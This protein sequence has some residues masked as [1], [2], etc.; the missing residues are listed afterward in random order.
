MG[1]NQNMRLAG[2]AG[3]RQVEGLMQRRRALASGAPGAAGEN[4]VV[5]GEDNAVSPGAV[6]R[7][8]M[9]ASRPGMQTPFQ[10]QNP[11][12]APGINLSFPTPGRIAEG[13]PEYEQMR[14]RMRGLTL[15][16]DLGRY[17]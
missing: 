3:R 7:Q 14:Q 8:E 1:A 5:M 6:M 13:S 2:D 4:P 17:F 15:Q 11:Q 10:T 12:G 9:F 16:G